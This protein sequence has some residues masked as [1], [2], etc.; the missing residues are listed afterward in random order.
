[1]LNRRFQQRYVNAS[2]APRAAILGGTCQ[3]VATLGAL[4]P[5]VYKLMR[6][7]A[8]VSSHFKIRLFPSAYHA[9]VLSQSPQNLRAD[10]Q[11]GGN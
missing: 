9:V 8:H 1:M 5:G 3:I 7:I 10:E 2:P 11:K 4:K 6:G